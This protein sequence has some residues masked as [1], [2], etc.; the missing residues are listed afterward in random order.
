MLSPMSLLESLDLIQTIP[1]WPENSI[2][3]AMLESSPLPRLT[4]YLPSEEY[5]TG[6]T[7]LILPG[8][9]YGRLSS[10][11]EGHRPAMLLASRGIAAAILEYRHAPYRY[12]TPLLDAQRAL[13]ILRQLAKSGGLPGKAAVGVL[14]FSAGGHLAGLLATQPPLPESHARDGVDKETPVP[15]FA[16]LI[17]PVVSFVSNCSHQGSCQNLLG[18]S[19]AVGLKEALS[20]EK[21]VHRKTPPFFLVHGQNDHVVPPQN[22]LLLAEACMAAECPVTL[23]LFPDLA[24]GIG[25]GDN[26]RWVS[27]FLEWLGDRK[28]S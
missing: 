1:L 28:T 9:G 21:A 19:P 27:A 13:R 11:K 2:G 25:A 22:S 7:V 10:A 4:Y 18:E 14:G 12:P 26:H 6:Q 5:R 17:Y 15:D 3:Q 24:H 23:H 8:G 20:L 16:A